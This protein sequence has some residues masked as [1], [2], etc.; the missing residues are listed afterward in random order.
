MDN[1]IAKFRNYDA[2]LMVSYVQEEAAY[3]QTGSGN[4][5]PY[6]LAKKMRAL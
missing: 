5:I 4:I 6:S 2:A 1:T 3:T